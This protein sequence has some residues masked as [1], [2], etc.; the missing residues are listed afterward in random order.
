VV[1]EEPL[2]FQEVVRSAS[3]LIQ[4]VNDTVKTINQMVTRLDKTL[5]TEQNLTNVTVAISNLKSA[6]E[7]AVVMIDG[8]TR[9]VATNSPPISKAV[10]NLVI[11]SEELDQLAIEMQQAVSTNKVE[12][13]AAVKNLESMTAILD[14][15]LKDIDAGRGLAG[16]LM[17]DE[18][19]K[20]DLRQIASNFSNLSSNLYRYGL[21][22]KPKPPKKD[23]GPPAYTGKT[24]F[25]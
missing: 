22:Y 8:V 21:L 13:T 2:N 11:F 4:G 7:K 23:A 6:S 9:L 14:R 15:L 17:R 20:V 25:K 18:T 19:L 16:A 3:G 24:P 5:F 10:T 1:C 12:L